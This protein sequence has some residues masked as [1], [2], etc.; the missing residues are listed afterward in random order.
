MSNLNTEPEATPNASRLALARRIVDILVDHKA[1]DVVLLDIGKQASFA[2][3][4]VICSGTS[5]R[6][7]KALMDTLDETL[8]NEGVRPTRVE[9]TP[10][11]GWVLLD[12]SDIIVHIFN[13]ATR[14]YYRLERIWSEA[15]TILRV[16]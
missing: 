15:T 1:A 9:G 16:Q 10:E 14:D 4:F 7:V 5:E 6:Q 8:D 12:F 13:S 2:D 11:T 3:Y